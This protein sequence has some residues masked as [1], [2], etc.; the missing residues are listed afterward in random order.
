MITHIISSD[1][2]ILYI[3]QNEKFAVKDAVNSALLQAGLTTWDSIEADVFCLEDTSLIIA[4]PRAPLTRR[5]KPNSPRL[6]RY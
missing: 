2:V 1:C 6:S 5:V 3:N 4:R